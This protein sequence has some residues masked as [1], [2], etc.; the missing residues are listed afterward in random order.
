MLNVDASLVRYI[1]IK[2]EHLI[3]NKTIIKLRFY[4]DTEFISRE[5]NCTLT[6]RKFES[7][8]LALSLIYKFMF[9]ERASFI[10]SVEY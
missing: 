7:F 3:C 5:T 9:S 4:F 10:H 2:P 6:T 1:H 8:L